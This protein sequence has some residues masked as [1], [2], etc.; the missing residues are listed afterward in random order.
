[1]SGG[2]PLPSRGAMPPLPDSAPPPVPRSATTGPPPTRG[3]G[4]R[5]RGGPNGGTMRGRGRGGRQRG[6][7]TM[8][9][10]ARTGPLENEDSGITFMGGIAPS[11]VVNDH[12]NLSDLQERTKR[13]E[14]QRI[15]EEAKDHLARIQAEEE[16][17]ARK[18]QKLKEKEDARIKEEERRKEEAE[19]KKQR[20]H[21][22]LERKKQKAAEDAEKKRQR[23]EE[24]TRLREEKRVQKEEF[25]KI[26][27]EKEDVKRKQQERED[28]KRVAEANLLAFQKEVK[29]RQKERKKET[30]RRIVFNQ[31]MQRKRAEE[32]IRRKR[33]D[34][35]FTQ[36]LKAEEEA[37]NRWDEQTAVLEKDE[38]DRLKQLEQ[39]AE[40]GYLTQPLTP[41]MSED[42]QQAPSY[43]GTSGSSGNIGA[44]LGGGGSG[45]GGGGT[46]PGSTSASPFP[47]TKPRG[48]DSETRPAAQSVGDFNDR[49]P[50]LPT[51]QNSSASVSL[52]FCSR[53]RTV[54][55][56]PQQ[57]EENG[58]GAEY[59]GEPTEHPDW[60]IHYDEN[61]YPYF[62]NVVTGESEWEQPF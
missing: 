34:D 22:D 37:N 21:E 31:E 2:P 55:A 38:Q 62:F 15:E 8:R 1:M 51:R 23:M 48:I 7:G 4:P 39:F 58:E 36:Q 57:E 20:A 30:D 60:F 12:T 46:V 44:T 18:M 41:R 45:G 54:P 16:R 43:S 53:A 33:F 26:R 24:E 56:A 6:A 32:D 49:A 14:A 52:P 10:Q 61:N 29:H 3:S 11:V 27:K 19:K 50:P 40:S 28:A 25:D 17:Q 5:G 13:A 59:E 9:A 42:Y 47:T 35:E